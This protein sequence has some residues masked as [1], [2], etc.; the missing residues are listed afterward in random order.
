MRRRDFLRLAAY[1]G[2][3]TALDWRLACGLLQAKDIYPNLRITWISHTQPGSGYDIIPRAMAPYLSKYIKEQVPGCKGGDVMIRNET[4]AAGRKAYEMVFRAE[5]DGYTIGGIDLSFITDLVTDKIDFDITQY[6]YLARLDASHKLVVAGKNGLKSWQEAMDAARISPLKIAVGQFGRANHVAGILLKEA[7]G[8][9]AKFIATKSTAE[10]MSMVMRGDTQVGVASEDSIA[11]LIAA[12]EVR[13]ILTYEESKD[14]PGATSLPAL[15]HPK[16]G[17][18]A[19]G[20]RCAIAPPGLPKE[21]T[22]ILVTAIK[23]TM[24]DKD[25]KDW[26]KKANFAMDPI[27]GEEA[28][29]LVKGYIQ[30]YNHIE[31]TLRKYLL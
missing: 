1:G 15:G 16:I 14:Y 31:P 20:Q 30:Y 11:N 4:A 19:A 27:Y 18:Y 7:L 10:N 2:A 3:A 22:R 13:V 17:A 9:N 28:T 23:K 8:F 12:K 29:N 5:P 26:E 24:D 21:M 25:F 6:T